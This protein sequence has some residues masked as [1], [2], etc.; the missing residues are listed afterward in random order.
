ML[1]SSIRKI[2]DDY[3]NNSNKVK[4]SRFILISLLIFSAVSMYAHTTQQS[5]D[6][7]TVELR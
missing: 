7:R 6:A 3:F 5:E 1:I 2:E 4:T